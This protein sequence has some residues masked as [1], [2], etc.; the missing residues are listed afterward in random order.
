MHTAADGHTKKDTITVSA[1]VMHPLFSCAFGFFAFA[2]RVSAVLCVRRKDT[3]MKTA[4]MSAKTII[5]ANGSYII[6][7]EAGTVLIKMADYYPN[8]RGE[9][10]YCEI[11]RQLF[12]EFYAQK[13]K[14]EANGVISLKLKEIYPH[15]DNGDRLITIEKSLYDEIIEHR[16]HTHTVTIRVKDIYPDDTSEYEYVEISDRVYKEILKSKRKE[17]AL[18]VQDSRNRTAFQFDENIGGTSIFTDSSEKDINFQ[19]LI[20][21]LFSAQGEELRKVALLYFIDGYSPV[22]IAKILKKNKP[23]VWK[24]I[25]VSKQIVKNAGVEYFF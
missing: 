8:Y 25:R 12:E 20:D 17:H 5:G 24:A 21:K 3:I 1:C 9:Q 23:N 11:S 16:K 22:Q 14:E 2:G 15:M 10:D 4:E 6:N 19:L 7:E 18:E 13:N